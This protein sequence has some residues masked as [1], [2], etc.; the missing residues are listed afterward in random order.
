[1]SRLAQAAVDTGAG[2]L[3]YTAPDQFNVDVNDLMIANTTGGSLTFWLYLVSAGQSPSRVNA[4]FSGVSIPANTTIQWTGSQTM[5]KNDYLHA[6]GSGA[7][8]TLTISGEIY[9]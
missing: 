4:L 5:N 3:V 1:M 7:G 8:I 6:V 2:T 9:R